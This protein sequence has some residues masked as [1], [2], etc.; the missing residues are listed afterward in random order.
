MHM[1]DS[2]V[3]AAIVAGDPGGLAAAYDKYAD[4]LFKYCR[5]LLRDP[6]DAADAVQ[7]TFVIA[8]TRL[9]GL[10]DPE[11]LQSWLY[12]VARNECLRI[13]RARRGVS[14]LD[15]VLDVTDDSADISAEAE[16]ADLRALF[17][18][19]KDGLN[20]GEREVIELQLRAGLE[21]GEVADVLG[22]SRNHAHTLLSRAREQ[23]ETCLGVLL[24]GRAGRDQ[25]G[26]LGAMLN[27]WDG[28]LTVLLRKR[29]HRHI[30]RCGTCTATQEYQLRPSMLLDL[31]PGAALAAG[32]ALSFRGAAGAPEGLRGHTIAL[33]TGHG[34]AAAAHSA[35]VL[36]RAGGFTKAGFPKPGADAVLAGQRGT[37]I[38]GRH[39]GGPRTGFMK[40]GLR[41]SSRSH[42]AVAAAV[43]IAV[44]VAAAAFALAGNGQ[45]F[46]PAADPNRPAASV[47]TPASQPATAGAAR[48]SPS[49]A[50]APGRPTPASSK[51]APGKTKPSPVKSSAPPP[52]KTSSPPV[53]TSSSGS[54]SHAPSP[55]STPAPAPGGTLS[56]SP[57][58]GTQSRPE[59]LMIAPGG[60]G[61]PIQ[62]SASGGTVRWSVT[63]AGDPD[64]L[65]SVSPASGTLTARSPA[66]T[67]TVTVSQFLFCGHGP[68]SPGECPTITLTPGGAV[69]SI[70]TVSGPRHHDVNPASAAVL[71]TPTPIDTAETRRTT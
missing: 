51:P 58:G 53:S 40:R 1:R 13:V 42:A 20:P 15:E 6:A 39:A 34:P 19:A 11:R 28:R 21:A 50:S 27:G 62:L 52:A 10:R 36:S 33:A 41:S 2:E 26:E 18:D 30:E 3:V 17:E 32:A 35:A 38:A 66:A 8:A 24:V 67:V 54:P 63:I 23:L 70:W 64:G 37:P 16:R 31:S 65:V 49:A 47:L 14:V 56:A 9:G 7:D 61:T 68:G 48:Q 4:P 12:A 46:T 57:A 22:V 69:Y 71:I 29:L 55:T 5:T 43:V 44:A 25:C 45:R 60:P 59:P